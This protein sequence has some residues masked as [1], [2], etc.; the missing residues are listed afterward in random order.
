MSGQE[1]SLRLFCDCGKPLGILEDSPEGPV[2]VSK[3]WPHPDPFGDSSPEVLAEKRRIQNAAP[4]LRLPLAGL[5][6]GDGRR[7]FHCAGGHFGAIEVEALRNAWAARKRRFVVPAVG[8]VHTRR[9]SW[10]N[11]PESSG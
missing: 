3:A 4:P 10:R 5:D 6:R 9:E 8:S 1:R 11:P 2:F 7:A